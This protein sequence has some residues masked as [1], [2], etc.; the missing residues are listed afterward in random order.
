MNPWL[1]PCGN[2]VIDLKTGDLLEGNP[3]D[4]ALGSMGTIYKGINEPC[5]AFDRF[6]SE[7]LNGDMELV[8]YMQR[9]L[10]HSLK[11]EQIDGALLVLHGYKRCS[12]KDTL[13]EILHKVLGNINIM[14]L[15]PLVLFRD[16]SINQTQLSFI[17]E[18]E[19]KGKRIVYASEIVDRLH[20]LQ[21]FPLDAVKYYT[22]GN[23]I[24]ARNL[25]NKDENKF[26]LT[27]LLIL[28]TNNLPKVAAAADAFWSRLHLVDLHVSF[29]ADP[30][31]NDEFQRQMDTNLPHKLEEEKS[32]ILSW[33]VRGCLEYQRQGGLH[34]PAS[35]REAVVKYRDRNVC[36]EY[37]NR[38]SRR[39]LA[40][41]RE[42]SASAHAKGPQ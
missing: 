19:L 20:K 6:M 11:L 17:N 2:G 23:S 37:M 33:L 28:L 34:P 21:S 16:S 27:H 41:Q 5:P 4:F 39:Y 12:G 31:P 22:G 38:N 15:N 8:K 24:T 13:M 42:K 40:S 35:V 26:T 25:Y 1:L 32:G 7:I 10:G 29:V 36:R 9:M 18:M 3:A 30:D 14:Q